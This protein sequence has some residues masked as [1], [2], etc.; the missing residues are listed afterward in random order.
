[1]SHELDAVYA[2][3]PWLAGAGEPQRLAGLTNVN[4]RLGPYVVRL[5]GA[6]THEYID[7][8]AEE[9]AAR[10]AADA[11]VSVEVLF[12]DTSDGLMVTRFLEGAATMSAEAFRAD[13]GAV[14]RAADVM[15][16]LHT[17][18]VPFAVEF[19]LFEAIDEYRALLDAKRA[20]LPDGFDAVR[21]EAER[22]RRALAAH[23]VA[24]VPSHCDPLCENFL[25][26]GSRMRLID[27]EYAG[28]FDP[29]WDLGDFS[30]EA[31]LTP[32]QDE[33]LL[34]AYFAGAPPAADR[35]RMVVHQAMCDVLWSLWG[36]L[37][38]ANDNPVED[39]WAYGCRRF[40]RCRELMATE[41]FRHSLD[42]LEVGP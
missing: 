10:A 38:H 16:R 32:D 2:R 27:Y 31:G 21:Q 24:Y 34:R 22:S 18:A 3:V 35:A 15:R 7:R 17:G 25:D 5:P 36:I 39:F 33:V 23:P 20:P 1:M 42:V 4:Y 11:G 12:F 9:R 13:D 30:V 19:H 29:M 6:G 8:V 37:Q 41:R 40:E 28:N 26:D 14:E